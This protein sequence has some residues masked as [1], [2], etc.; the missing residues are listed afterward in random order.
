MAVH[1]FGLPTNSR[2]KEAAWLLLQWATSQEMMAYV[3]EKQSYQGV[4]RKSVAGSKAYKDKF[5]IGGGDLG[6]IRQEAF[7]TAQ[8]AYRVVPEFVPIGD[9]VG[10]AIQQIA[11]RQKSA[12]AAMDDA[13]KDVVEVIK[14]AGY[15][16][17]A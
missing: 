12:K 14:K 11:T 2:Q 4:T 1:G 8:I 7:D 9:R 5:T 3:M 6:A 10:I 15:K 17:S 16:I 13:Q